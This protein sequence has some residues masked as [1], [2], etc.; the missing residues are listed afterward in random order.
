MSMLMCGFHSSAKEEKRGDT[1]SARGAG[2]VVGRFL[3]W[4]ERFPLG[5]FMFFFGLLLL[6]FSVFI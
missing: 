1:V 3:V 2:W 4:V 5:P 6:F